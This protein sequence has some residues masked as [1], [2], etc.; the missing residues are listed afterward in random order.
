MSNELVTTFVFNDK[1]SIKIDAVRDKLKGTNDDFNNLGKNQTFGKNIVDGFAAATQAADAFKTKT[2]SVFQQPTISRW[3]ENETEKAVSSI[4]KVETAI[5]KLNGKSYTPSQP[6]GF[7]LPNEPTNKPNAET[8]KSLDELKKKADETTK[9][10]QSIAATRLDSGQVNHLTK[11]II[12]AGERSRQ[13]TRDITSIKRE[14]ANPN[15]KS[16]IA[17]LTDE[18][19]GAENEADRLNRKLNTVSGGQSGSA[20]SKFGKLRG[21][22]AVFRQAGLMQYGIDETSINFATTIAE[23]AEIG[24]P[25]LTVFGAIAAAGAII[26]KQTQNIREDAE[27]RLRTE[28]KIASELNKQRI[29]LTEQNDAYEKQRKLTIEQRKNSA[30]LQDFSIPVLRGR[31]ELLDKLL[32]LKSHD[33][34]PEEQPK[35]QQYRR[36]RDNLDNSLYAYD[37]QQELDRKAAPD[38]AFNQN[39]E[40]YKKKQEADLAYQRKSAEQSVRLA[41]QNPNNKLNDLTK[42]LGQVQNSGDLTA[43]TQ[44]SLIFEIQGKIEQLTEKIKQAKVEFKEFIGS[45]NLPDN[46]FVKVLID[47]DTAGYRAQ[48]KFKD[49]GDEFIKAAEKADRAAL[50]KKLGLLTYETDSKALGFDQQARKLSAIPETGF[51]SFQKALEGVE[52]SLNFI[53]RDNSL[54]RRINEAQFYANVYNPNNPKS[55]A[56]FNWRGANDDISDIGLQIRSAREDISSIKN[57]SLDGTGVYGRGVAADAILS[58]VPPLKDLVA[59][60][61]DPRNR[62]DAQSLIGEFRDA[63]N[64]SRDAQRQKFQDS[65]ENQKTFQFGKTFA[66]EQIDLINKS[67][68]TDVDKAKR[69]Y[70]VVTALG[71][72][73]DPTLKRQGIQD[74]LASAQAA[75]DERTE[76]LQLQRDLGKAVGALQTSVEAVD[77]KLGLVI[78][79]N[80]LKIDAKNQLRQWKSLTARTARSRCSVPRQSLK[81]CRHWVSDLSAVLLIFNL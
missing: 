2:E 70:D 18:L 39:W 24:I 9:S 20:S 65:I 30:D 28:E 75:R 51:A 52:N 13:L 1:D 79:A 54:G 32:D 64:A 60:L 53:V 78:S 34:R 57:Q 43:N 38:K 5:D 67:A 17:F 22:G 27:V 59:Q 10:F 72:D 6:L 44:Q 63:L 50:S 77:T 4:K 3:Y 61:N 73:L 47:I 55:F 69:R 11:E 12:A 68:L 7:T 21:F 56:E 62:G 23:K 35:I 74:A 37:R 41:L 40:N 45:A 25:T 15:R 71:N 16:S 46:P 29:A 81:I 48:K 58:V 14:L 26:V 31:K 33:E 76:A 80:G 19:R 49:L 42:L 36:E 66:H 8:F